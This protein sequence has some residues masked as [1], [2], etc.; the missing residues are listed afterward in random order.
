LESLLVGPGERNHF[1]SLAFWLHPNRSTIS[2]LQVKI[3]TH[4]K[5]TQITIVYQRERELQQQN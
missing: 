2:H 5:Y 3:N 4:I 1:V